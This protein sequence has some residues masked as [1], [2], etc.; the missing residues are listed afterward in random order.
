[1]KKSLSLVALLTLSFSLSS[2]AHKV[3]KEQVEEKIEKVSIQDAE[4][5]HHQC[6]TSIN[7][8]ET[9]TAEQK[10]RLLEIDNKY[11]TDQK[12]IKEELAKAKVVLIGLISE[13]DMN[14]KEYNALKKKIAELNKLR[15]QNGFEA[16]QKARLVLFPKKEKTSLEVQNEKQRA[17][18]NIIYRHHLNEL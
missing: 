10:A 3:A 7:E 4:H 18:Y 2:C 11:T 13:K 16:A 5:L 8:S 9:L 15:V 6:I 14:Q 12:R 1:M 17:M